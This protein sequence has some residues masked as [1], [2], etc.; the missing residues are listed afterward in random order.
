[1]PYKCENENF[2]G[3]VLLTIFQYS[4]WSSLQIVSFADIFRVITQEEHCMT[5]LKMA[6]KESSLQIHVHFN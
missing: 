2:S 5:T 4:I 6:V 1:M 3:K